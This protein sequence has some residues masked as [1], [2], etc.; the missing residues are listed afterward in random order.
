VLVGAAILQ[1]WTQ[2]AAELLVH[3]LTLLPRSKPVI[4]PLLPL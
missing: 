1:G 2:G 3:A 4:E